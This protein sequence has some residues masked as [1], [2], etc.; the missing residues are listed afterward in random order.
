[1][2]NFAGMVHYEDTFKKIDQIQL[3]L[4]VMSSFL[5]PNLK[6]FLIYFINR[7]AIRPPDAKF[8]LTAYFFQLY[9]MRFHIRI[10][11]PRLSEVP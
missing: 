7:N 11:L 6:D 1:M 10:Q 4:A 2:P 5:D 3:S 8:Q 9:Q